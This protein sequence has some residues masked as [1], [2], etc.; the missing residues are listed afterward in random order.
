MPSFRGIPARVAALLAMAAA[1]G[2]YD[3][4][5]VQPGPQPASLPL[6]VT[7]APGGTARVTEAFGPFIT[8]LDATLE[9]P[10]PADSMRLRVF[11][12]R[13][14]TGLRTDIPGVP[15]TL[16]AADVASAQRRKLNPLRTGMLSVA[17]GVALVSLP[18]LI[19]NAG[20]GGGSGPPSGPPQP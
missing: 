12:T 13:H 5:A 10:W 3:Y 16:A 6:R 7:L 19:Q 8:A 14:Q 1:S 9:G 2:C 4:L 17:I 18:S 11:A 15:V 20:G